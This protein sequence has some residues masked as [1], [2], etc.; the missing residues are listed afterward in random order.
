MIFML[1]VL[2]ALR[3]RSMGFAPRL[4]DRPHA[5]TTVVSTG[6]AQTPAVRWSRDDQKDPAGARRDACRVANL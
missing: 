1:I 6:T 2:I 3:V 5:D 4:W